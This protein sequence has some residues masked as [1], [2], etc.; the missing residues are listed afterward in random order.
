MHSVA[1][2]P[3]K[4]FYMHENLQYYRLTVYDA[5]NPGTLD[6]APCYTPRGAGGWGVL[7]TPPV[8]SR[9]SW[10]TAD[11][12]TKLSGPYLVSIWCILPKFQKNVSRSFSKSWVLETSCSVIFGQTVANVWKLVECTGLKQ[13][14]IQTHQKSYNWTFYKMIISDFFYSQNSK[15]HFSKK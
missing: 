15:F 3:N 6:V 8:F 11:I 7:G 13:S 12:D 1:R 14:T 10:T 5:T 4:H 2:T 9:Y